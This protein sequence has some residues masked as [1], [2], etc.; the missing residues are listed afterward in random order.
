MATG[1]DRPLPPAL[2]RLTEEWR[3]QGCRLEL[4]QILGPQ[5]WATQEI[6]ESANLIA[7]T[8]MVLASVNQT[9]EATT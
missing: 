6:S 3:Q 1:A 5:F 8:C 2:A 4:K 7:A 9:V